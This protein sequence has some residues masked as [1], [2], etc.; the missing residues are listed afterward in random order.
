MKRLMRTSFAV[1]LGATLLLWNPI[2]PA[3]DFPSRPIKVIVPFAAGSAVDS[4]GR[5][6]ANDLT[7]RLRTPVVVENRAGATGAIGS[8]SVAKSPADGYTLLL[9]TTGTHAT[10][11]SIYP[12]LGYNPIRD[13][14]PVGF[15]VSLSML[16]ASYPGAPFRTLPELID[17][18]RANPGKL[19]F[20]TTTAP[21]IVIGESIKS[22]AKL[23][24]VYVPYKSSLGALNDVMG[25]L[26]PLMVTD[27]GVG[28]P[29]IK[30]G[31]LRGIA[32]TSMKASSMLP[33]VP[34]VAATL[35]GF[36]II[37]WFGMFAPANT[38]SPVVDKLAGSLQQTLQD[39]PIRDRMTQLGFETRPMTA[40]Q[41]QSFVREENERW[42]VWV[43]EFGIGAQ[44]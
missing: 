28:T 35:P 7:A 42:A 1:A 43:K 24:I 10:N 25:G 18:A 29:Q 36:E 2:V 8:E 23:D 31:K 21:G 15:V 41:F 12:N 30:A 17:Y 14:A 40:A 33:D 38:P 27:A 32:T 19:S 13:F 22:R 26:V 16:I 6:I 5:I 39:P 20:A 44:Q 34:P 11:P 37:T 3:Q 9:G 4:V